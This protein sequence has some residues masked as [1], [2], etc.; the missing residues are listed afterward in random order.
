MSNTT[1]LGKLIDDG[2]TERDAIHIAV[3]PVTSVFILKPGQ[4]VTLD[5][6]ND[7]VKP[8]KAGDGI[9]IVDPFL[10]NKTK[11][12]D[13]FYVLL[14]PQTITS[15]KHLWTHPAF[16]FTGNEPVVDHSIAL[17]KQRLEIFASDTAVTYEELMFA[18][19]DYLLYGNYF[20]QG[21]KFEGVSMPD[22]FWAD[23][24]TVTGEKVPDDAK[25]HFFTCSC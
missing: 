4:H 9:G 8:C 18:A 14:Y 13:V 23:Y 25:G 17:A 24:E 3:V 15:L 6:A 10:V 1:L 22:S 19:S 12:G 7:R 2:N 16:R 11:S 5:N 20:I 21:G